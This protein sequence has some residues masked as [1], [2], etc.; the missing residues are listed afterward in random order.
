[1]S[2]LNKIRHK[3]R[4]S[5]G[6][7]KKGAGRLIGNRRLKAEGRTDEKTGNVELAAD[8]ISDAF[9]H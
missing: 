8:K 2:I 5:K 9:K 4:T 1:V 7:T 3:A 6:T